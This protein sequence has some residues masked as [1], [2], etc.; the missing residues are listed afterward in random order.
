MRK[1]RIILT[2]QAELDIKNGET[3]YSLI[4]YNIINESV[5]V[6]PLKDNLLTEKRHIN[7]HLDE[8]TRDMTDSIIKVILSNGEDV[9]LLDSFGFMFTGWSFIPI[10]DVLRRYNP[11]E[12]DLKFIEKR[13]DGVKIFIKIGQ[14]HSSDGQTEPRMMYNNKYVHIDKISNESLQRYIKNIITAK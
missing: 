11:S 7:N 9:D 2:P 1:R 4:D 8:A 6:I 5:C 12:I 10:D 3:Y 14:I 13:N